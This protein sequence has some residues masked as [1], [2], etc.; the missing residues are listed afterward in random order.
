M[1]W[2]CTLSINKKNCAENKFMRTNKKL[3]II[4]YM[5]DGSIK[6]RLQE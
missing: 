5:Y 4:E 6:E 2:N 3:N 1:Y